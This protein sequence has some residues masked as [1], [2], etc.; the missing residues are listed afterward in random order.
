MQTPILARLRFS[1]CTAARTDSYYRAHI[2]LSLSYLPAGI[3]GGG[4]PSEQQPHSKPGD[5]IPGEPYGSDL[6]LIVASASDAL[7]IGHVVPEEGHDASRLQLGN[8]SRCNCVH[9]V[10][11]AETFQAI[12]DVLRLSMYIMNHRSA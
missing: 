2:G 8:Y 1:R 11:T 7:I 10:T 5:R 12:L 4:H 3:R 9:N 6:P